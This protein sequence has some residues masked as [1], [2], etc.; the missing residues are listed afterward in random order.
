MWLFLIKYWSLNDLTIIITLTLEY[1]FPEIF[2]VWKL[3]YLFFLLLKKVSQRISEKK[4]KKV[5]AKCHWFQSWE[6]NFTA[7]VAWVVRLG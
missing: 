4:G 3:L 2:C 5:V 1:T 7:V 6:C